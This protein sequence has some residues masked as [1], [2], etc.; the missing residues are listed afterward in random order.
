MFGL[1]KSPSFQDETL[2]EL[3][4][5]RGHWRGTINLAGQDVPLVLAGGKDQPDTQALALARE[6]AKQYPGWRPAIE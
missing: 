1:F 2:G 3:R 4:H 6:L 5:A